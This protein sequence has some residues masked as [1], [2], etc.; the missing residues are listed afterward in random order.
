MVKKLSVT[1]QRYRAVLELLEE[2]ATVVEVTARYGATRQ[3]VHH[4]VHRYPGRR[5]DA[6]ADRSHRPRGCL[7]QISGEVE[8]RICELRRQHPRSGLRRL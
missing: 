6:L 2:H 7:H 1:E 3:T 5:P 4:W 8:A